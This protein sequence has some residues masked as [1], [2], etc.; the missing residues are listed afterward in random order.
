MGNPKNAVSDGTIGGQV[1]NMNSLMPMIPA[2]FLVIRNVK[3]HATAADWGGD[4][5]TLRKM[6]ADSQGQSS[7]MSAGGGAG[8]SLGFLTIGGTGSHSE[9]HTSN[10]FNN[11]QSQDASSNYGWSFDGETLEIKGAQIVA[12]LSEIVPATAPLGDPGLSQ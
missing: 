3:I 10:S 9:G 7:S 8:F 1:K 2:Q 11:S 6:N 4:G 5:Q 12:W